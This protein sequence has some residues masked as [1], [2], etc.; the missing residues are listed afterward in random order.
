M[1]FQSS[2][3]KLQQRLLKE[4]FEQ[5]IF[6]NQSSAFKGKIDIIDLNPEFVQ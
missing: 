1:A 5:E 6:S 4:M 2:N 3:S